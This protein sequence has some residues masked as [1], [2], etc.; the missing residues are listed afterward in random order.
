MLLFPFNTFRRCVIF[1][2]LRKKLPIAAVYYVWYA[3]KNEFWLQNSIVDS[4]VTY[5]LLS[6]ATVKKIWLK[7]LALGLTSFEVVNE[8][9]INR[10]CTHII[11]ILRNSVFNLSPDQQVNQVQTSLVNE[12]TMGGGGSLARDALKNFKLLAADGKQISS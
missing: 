9:S 10:V 3:E 12:A 8:I 2:F 5:F 1:H 6:S 11:K 4:N 7:C